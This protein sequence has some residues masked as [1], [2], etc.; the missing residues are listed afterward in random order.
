MRWNLSAV[1]IG[2]CLVASAPAFAESGQRLNE[3]DSF[4]V[5]E[6][7]DGTYI[8]VHGNAVPTFSVFKLSEPLRLFVDISNSE[9]KGELAPRSVDNGVLSKVALLEFEDA[10]RSVARLIVGFDRAAHYDVRADG[11]DVVIFVDGAARRKAPR[12]ATRR[13]AL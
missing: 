8:R 3:V 9:V 10:S 13:C 5:A 4:D 1:M 6:K 11:N 7:P 12:A 2:A